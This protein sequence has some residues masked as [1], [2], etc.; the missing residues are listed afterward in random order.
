[1]SRITALGGF[2]WGRF[3][4]RGPPLHNE[5]PT[6]EPSV[7]RAGDTWKWTKHAG[8]HTPDDGWTLKYALHHKGSAAATGTKLEITATANPDGVNHD[9][10]VAKTDT[11][12]LLPGNWTWVAYVE[13]GSERYTYDAGVLFVEPNLALAA[14]GTQQSHNEKMLAAIQSVLQGRAVSDIESYQIAGRAVN[15]MPVA[16]LLKLE[17]TYLARV[18]QERNP[19][20]FGTTHHVHF[21]R[22]S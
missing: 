19:G 7:V 17:S 15:K 20:R 12:D 10:L 1:M 4:F 16:E 8:D 3:L 9:V 6:A 21:T 14:A 5:T 18:R 22:P 11:D 13:K 2:P